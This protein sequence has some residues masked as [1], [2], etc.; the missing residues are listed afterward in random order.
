MQTSAI[1]QSNTTFTPESGK[2]YSIGRSF[3]QNTLGTAILHEMKS[4]VSKILGLPM[5]IGWSVVDMYK[6]LALVHYDD[7]FEETFGE[8]R[9]VVVDTDVGAVIAPS[10]GYTPTVIGSEIMVKNGNTVVVNEGQPDVDLPITIDDPNVKFK[11]VHEGVV[12]R[13]FWYDG[14]RYSITHKRLR[15]LKS[16]WGNSPFF[17]DMYKAAGY[18]SDEELFDTTKRFSTSCY[19]FLVSHPSLLVG[20]K[21][22]VESPYLVFLYHHVI[23]P[24]RPS[25]ET[26]PGKMAFETTPEITGKVSTPFIHNPPSLTLEQVNKHLKFGYYDT[27]S[28]DDYRMYTGEAIIAYKMDQ[29]NVSYIVKIN[30]P[31]YE[32]RC[33]M[34]GDN[35]NINHQFYAL[36]NKITP[37]IKYQNDANQEQ[38]KYIADF[39]KKFIVTELYDKEALLSIYNAAGTILTLPKSNRQELLNHILYDRD[40]RLRI[41]WINY[42]LSLPPSSQKAGLD[43]LDEYFSNRKK[44]TTWLQQIERTHKDINST[45]YIDRVKTIITASRSLARSAMKGGA[46]YTS[47]G[48]EMNLG[49]SIRNTIRNL[50][51]KE[52]GT[53]LYKLI[54]AM[55]KEQQAKDKATSE[56][57]A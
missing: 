14:E 5:S 43:I 45:E 55:K 6:S 44:V 42:V 41:L 11:R 34:R 4:K 17:L 53:S 54:N 39:E 35:H 51:N 13:E 50:I 56:A 37:P 32:H 28:C 52:H 23:D 19:S 7:G 9:G 18:P 12:F 16:R 40:T 48:R 8:L 3:G 10:F 1:E 24:K 22:I 25:E 38:E 27:F 47:R 29:G 2:T 33:V 30:S 26:A 21:Q 20:T 46:N 49:E 31:S 15:P 36:M 57:N